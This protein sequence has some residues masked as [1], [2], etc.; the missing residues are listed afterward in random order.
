MLCSSSRRLERHICNIGSI[1]LASQVWPACMDT[2]CATA[3]NNVHVNAVCA[4]SARYAMQSLSL[5]KSYVV[6]VMPSCK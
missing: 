6:E 5:L 3:K 4:D 1:E 2:S